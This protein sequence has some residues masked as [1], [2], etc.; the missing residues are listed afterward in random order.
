MTD[1]LKE[2]EDAIE[3]WREGALCQLDVPE[4][5]TILEALTFMKD[6]Q[7]RDI[8]SAPKDGSRVLGLTNYGWEVVKWCD[9]EYSTGDVMDNS[10]YASL[11]WIGTEQ[12]STCLPYM[13]YFDGTVKSKA[14]NQI[15]KWMPLPK[16]NEGIE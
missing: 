16:L 13:E 9:A 11:G 10:G 8:E 3:F 15:T 6:M 2:I 12:D 4:A 7:W 5:K 1:K 14:H